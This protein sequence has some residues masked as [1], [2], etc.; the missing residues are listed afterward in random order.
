[1]HRALVTLALAIVIASPTGAAQ[2]RSQAMILGSA[3]V[4]DGDTVRI[5][6][7]RIRLFGV[8]APEGK[9]SCL[10]EGLSW[11]C[12]QE[13]AKYLRKIVAGQPLSCEVRDRD[14]Y[15]RTVA[16]CRLPDGR[17]IGAEMVSGGMALAYRQYGGS[18]YDGAEAEAKKF[19]RGLWAGVFQSPWEWRRNSKAKRAP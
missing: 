9:Q 5:G 11:L 8:D 16:I 12:G 6:D 4:T 19:A 3:V 17:D 1:M 13:S 7:T 18:M 14:R 10:R 15:G 2:K